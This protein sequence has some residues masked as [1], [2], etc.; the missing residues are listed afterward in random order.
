MRVARVRSILWMTAAAAVAI[1]VAAII[2]AVVW[3]LEEIADMSSPQNSELSTQ[4]AP[5]VVPARSSAIP[6]VP[7]LAT[8]EPAWRLPLRRPLVDP[9]AP[10]AVAAKATRLSGLNVRLIGTIV[11]G[12]RPRGVFLI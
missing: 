3:P 5:P 6:Q 12:E 10:P 2:A 9:P 7:P 1:A 4:P 8:F 11:D